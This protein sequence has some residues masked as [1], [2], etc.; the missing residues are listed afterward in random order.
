MSPIDAAEDTAH[1]EL[2]FSPDVKFVS[3][4]RRFVTELYARILSDEVASS[5]LAVATH[6]L[7]DNAVLYSLDGGTTLRIGVRRDRDD[8]RVCIETKNRATPEHLDAVRRTLDR[9]CAATDPRAH[10]QALMRETAKRAYGSGLG[11]ARVCAESDM[12]VE[13][14]IE[15]DVVHLRAVASFKR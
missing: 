10:L 14:K 8:V 7:L 2:K 6:E 1:F 13:H 11:L 15:G 5:K 12:N 9:L 3:T 4:V